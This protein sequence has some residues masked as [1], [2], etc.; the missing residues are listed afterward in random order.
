MIPLSINPAQSLRRWA[1]ILGIC[2]V[3]ASVSLTGLYIWSLT[4]KVAQL[5]A[6][7]TTAEATG[8]ADQAWRKGH[9]VLTKN[10]EETNHATEEVLERNQDWSERPVPSDVADRV[11]K[12]TDSP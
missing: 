6:R 3:L 4:R 8:A 12:R 2:L 9:V 1:A 10:K 7:A 11:R 5:E